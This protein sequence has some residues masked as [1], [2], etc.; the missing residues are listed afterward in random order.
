FGPG[1]PHAGPGPLR[2]D[3]LVLDAEDWADFRTAHPRV[4]G[5][6]EEWVERLG[7]ALERMPGPPAA[8]RNG[9]RPAAGAS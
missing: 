6:A 4:R 1:S 9:R 7:R 2:V 8:R 3:A 5:T